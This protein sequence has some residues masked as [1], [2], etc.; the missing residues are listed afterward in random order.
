MITKILWTSELDKK[1]VKLIE[2]GLTYEQIAIK[3]FDNATLHN[4]VI[5][6]IRRHKHE[7]PDMKRPQVRN[8]AKPPKPRKDPAKRPEP[9]KPKQDPLRTEGMNLM[10]AGIDNCRWPRD[11]TKVSVPRCCGALIQPGMVYC[12]THCNLAYVASKRFTYLDKSMPVCIQVS[13]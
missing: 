3:L 2:E 10:D 6:R 8:V 5:G 7:F 11:S 1:C 12:P 4:A 13:A 9:Y